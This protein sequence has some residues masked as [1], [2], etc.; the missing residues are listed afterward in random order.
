MLDSPEGVCA[1]QARFKYP[2]TFVLFSMCD[3]SSRPSGLRV[4]LVHVLL[5]TCDSLFETL[6]ADR[7]KRRTDDP[8]VAH[9]RLRPRTGSRTEAER[10]AASSRGV[11]M[12]VHGSSRATG[13][14]MEGLSGTGMQAA[15]RAK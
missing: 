6:R 14:A 4:Q 5:G 3:R 9:P 15:R 8:G 13:T 2:A 1:R 11:T 12:S 10:R 7:P